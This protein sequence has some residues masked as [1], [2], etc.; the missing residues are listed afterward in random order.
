MGLQNNRLVNVLSAQ[1][2][3]R[4]IVCAC[5]AALVAMSTGP[6]KASTY[7]VTSTAD[8]GSTGTL[9]WAINQA[10]NEENGTININVGGTI[11][12][13]SPLPVITFE[14]SITGVAGTTIN[15]NNLYRPFFIDLEAEQPLETLSISNLTISNGMAHGGNGGDGAFGGGGGLGAG[16]AIFVNAGAVTLSN[17]T[18]T[19]SK[20]VGG[21]GGNA[22]DGTGGGGGGLGGNGASAITVGWVGGSG[23]GGGGGGFY[24]N[25]G[26]GGYE[27]GNTS[28]G[29]GGGQYFNGGKGHDFAG[30]G[31]GGSAG[32][33]GD[34]PDDFNADGGPGGAGGG[35]R[36]GNNL[37]GFDGSGA[38]QAGGVGGGGGGGGQDNNQTGN[39]GAGGRFGGGGGS[40]PGANGGNGGEFGGGGGTS[41]TPGSGDTPAGNGGFGGGG[42]GG[43]IGGS[44]GFGAGSGAGE[45]FSTSTGSFGGRG[46]FQFNTEFGGGGGGAALGGAIFVR[47]SNGASLTMNDSNIDAGSI[48]AGLGGALFANTANSEAGSPGQAAGSMMF[49]YG[50]NTTI[51]VSN[52]ETISGSIAD[53]A[54]DG[55]AGAIT[56]TGNG[57]LTLTGTNTYTG[58]TTTNGGTLI[59]GNGQTSGS[60]MGNIIANG[61]VAFQRSDNIT[62]AGNISGGG[63][64]IQAG[65]GVLTLTGALSYTGSTSINN[66]AIDVVGH[67][68]P[69]GITAISANTTLEYDTST[70][71]VF[72][73]GAT[74]E[75]NGTL[76]KIGG[77]FLVFG[78]SGTVNVNL[79]AGALVDI[80]GGIVNGSSS[81]QGNWS[82]NQASLK[83]ASGATFNAVEGGSAYA[84]QFDALTGAG[85]LQGGYSG[86]PN[87]ITTI[88]LGVA[89][90]GGTFSGVIS[91]NSG[92][93]LAIIKAGSGTEI[94]TGT[95]TYTGGTSVSGGTLQIGSGGTVG[96]ITGNVTDNATIT[97]DRSDSVTFGGNISGTGSLT[98]SGA[99]TL[100]LTGTNT[101][102]G[103]TNIN[104]GTVQIGNGSTAGSITGGATDNGTLA[105][106]RSDSITYSGAI[107]GSGQIT[108]AGAGTLVLSGSST[109]FNSATVATI[110]AGTLQFGN[111]GLTGLVFGN[112]LDNAAIAFNLSGATSLGL[113]ISGSG[114]VTQMGPGTIALSQAN[115]YLGGTTVSGG[116]L[117]IGNGTTGSIVGNVVN[118][119]TLGFGRS[120]SYTFSGNISGIGAVTQS[121]GG[122]LILTGTNT[123]SGTTT[124]SSGSLQIGAG[125][126]SGSLTSSISNSTN[127]P[128]IFSRSDNSTYS[129]ALSGTGGL[130]K[131]SAGVLTLMQSNTYAGPTIVNGGTLQLSAPVTA[132]AGYAAYYSFD[133]V[134]GNTVINGGSLGSSTNATIGG[135]GAIVSGGLHG[136]AL[137]FPSSTAVLTP[138][139]TIPLAAASPGN[140]ASTESAWFNGLN[141]P[142][143]A[144]VLFGNTNGDSEALLQNSA[145][146]ALAN[147]QGSSQHSAGAD[148]SAY[149]T[150]WHQLTV[151]ENEGPFNFIFYIDGQPVGTISDSFTYDNINAFGNIAAG[152][153]PFA[154]KLDDIYVYNNQAL[155]ATQVQQLYNS[156]FTAS[157]PTGTPV[158]LTASGATLDI[159]GNT[160]S[161]GSLTGVAGTSVLLGTGS[162]S[163]GSSSLG[164]TFSG[165]I[166]GA[167][168]LTKAGTATLIFAGANSYSA[169]TTI[170]AGTLQIGNG[171]TTGIIAG[172]VL[173]NAALTFNRSDSVAFAGN[174]SGNG[175]LNQNGSGT[176]TLSG[177][178]I[179]SG[180]TTISTGKLTIANLSS[181]ASGAVTVK[182]G[183]TLQFANTFH[184]AIVLASL[185][186][187]PTGTVDL[188]KTDLLINYTGT[189]PYTNTLTSMK[190]A[191]DGGK[192]DG[193]GIGSSVLI[194]GT[195]LAIYDN[196]INTKSSFDNIAA[197][198][199]TIVIKYTWLGDANLDGIV[200]SADLTA[201]SS[202]GTT[203]QTGDF[204]YDGKVNADDYAL[205][206]LGDTAS[207]GQ[208]ITTVLPEPALTG[209]LASA[210]IIRRRRNRANLLP[211]PQ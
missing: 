137:S 140:H 41:S 37:L 86:N 16:G 207:S 75:G 66:G 131:N 183:A 79:S 191:Y 178:N 10:N 182:S 68:M 124:V 14:G 98:Q 168:S 101:Y 61:N 72:Q 143:L 3:R 87:A 74:I 110:S 179:Y 4:A 165:A 163:V 22:G 9:R 30:G 201:I 24:G 206:M 19:N 100:I 25:G 33:G 35:G 65:T 90:G 204:N 205:Y 54:I 57:V 171:S 198:S 208:S 121:G 114:S 53:D 49:L 159:N 60:V 122:A 188:A 142:N 46:A 119:A 70:T 73:T 104:S 67:S 172:N 89:G 2:R 51:S 130:T 95:N 180:G 153:Q 17:V 88:T 107:S 127:N 156:E 129:G 45:D 78:G 6:A 197:D 5:A 27:Q 85:N 155:T 20:A 118:N 115:T 209:I 77:N 111:G 134:S 176:L 97:F 82:T 203:W 146:Y 150:G 189:N 186:V 181:L 7:Q 91:D 211:T 149:A 48:T 164:T 93:H 50:G 192:W 125:S 154:Q 55:H 63:A 128:V 81:Y 200:N 12:L 29:G 184:G 103:S 177:T 80:E 193:V 38:G 1:T 135:T 18:T 170:S 71:T 84:Q 132:P 96:S 83:I 202:T 58:G 169:G 175:S 11:T 64:L 32:P 147:M 56:K 69:G 26:L 136:N 43:L 99:G 13:T 141:A 59:I 31:G 123:Y 105:F 210:L 120:N 138:N 34:A 152:G 185:T 144:R 102:A 28:G 194:A 21:N 15:G 162:L 23:G 160:Q 166:S 148:L 190:T 133:N 116:T 174:I 109:L 113:S 151:V 167:G 195:S 8:D 196:S 44:S 199:T 187:Q 40:A 145:G 112:M 126:T 157:L 47:A 173:D 117:V 108:K 52:T 158:Q 62:F 92:G 161:I 39:G 76:E 94:L 42:G 106:D 36:G 139:T